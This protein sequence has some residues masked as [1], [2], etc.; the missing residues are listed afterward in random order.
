[1]AIRSNIIIDQ[2]ADYELTIN[3]SDAN[4]AGIS[5]AGFTGKSE[6]RKYYTSTKKYDFNVT[7]SANTGE[8][9]LSMNAA[10]TARITAGRYVYDCILVSNTNLVSRIVEGI[11]TINPRVSKYA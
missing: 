6:I 4:T 3:V 5:L 11:V 10:N 1:M 8:V 7:I 9:T 2:G